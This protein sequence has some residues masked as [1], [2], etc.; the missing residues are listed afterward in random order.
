MISILFY[1]FIYCNADIILNKLYLSNYSTVLNNE[2]I[3][4]NANFYYSIINIHFFSLSV[5]SIYIVKNFINY[6]VI[7]KDS[8]ALAFIYIKYSLTI[9]FSENIFFMKNI[10]P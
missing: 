1:V 3:Q 10:L 5:Y 7:S 9:F 8:I 6:N 2:L 4:S